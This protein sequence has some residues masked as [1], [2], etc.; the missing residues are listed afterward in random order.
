MEIRYRA[1]ES[2]E[3]VIWIV[4]LL[5]HCYFLVHEISTDKYIS[6]KI[7][8]VSCWFTMLT[9]HFLKTPWRTR[10]SGPQLSPLNYTYTLR[11]YVLNAECAFSMK[12]NEWSMKNLHEAW[13]FSTKSEEQRMKNEVLEWRMK[14]LGRRRQNPMRDERRAGRSPPG[15]SRAAYAMTR[16]FYVKASELWGPWPQMHSSCV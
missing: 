3:C 4:Y 5:N 9:H 8:G 16:A 15:G 7:L 14:S 10:S 11:I 1:V 6:N 12:N 13:R 2:C